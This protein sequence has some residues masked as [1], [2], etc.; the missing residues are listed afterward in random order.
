[1]QTED[2]AGT[3]V[4]YNLLKYRLFEI[5][6]RAWYSVA[7]FLRIE[8]LFRAHS[9]I[10]IT[11]QWPTF[12]MEN[13]DKIRY[14]MS[15]PTLAQMLEDENFLR[16]YGNPETTEVDS[17]HAVVFSSISMKHWNIDDLE[18]YFVGDELEDLPLYMKEIARSSLNFVDYIPSEWSKDF[19]ERATIDAL[20]R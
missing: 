18:K 9:P 10:N 13:K 19:V 15:P 2:A 17:D 12:Y 6:D 7:Y 11:D 14:K 4:Y 16:E 20:H 1:M 5:E 8:P 3:Y